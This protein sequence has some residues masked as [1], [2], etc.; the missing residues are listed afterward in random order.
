MKPSSPTT[1][2]ASGTPATLT[3]PGAVAGSFVT[4]A[5]PAVDASNTALI[6]QNLCADVV[7]V[8]FGTAVSIPAS[9]SNGTRVNAGQTVLIES[10]AGAATGIG[11]AAVSSMGGSL[12]VQRGTATTATVFA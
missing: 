5:M 3:V 12:V 11:I 7:F 4:L 8:Q 10:T 1:F 6:V 9:P 2:T